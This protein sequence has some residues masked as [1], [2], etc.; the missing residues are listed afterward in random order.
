MSEN[1]LVKAYS[2]QHNLDVNEFI[3][4]YMTFLNNILNDLWQTIEWKKKGKRLIPLIRKDKFF[5]KEIRDKYI[6]KWI[7]SKHYID[8]AIKQAYSIINSWRKRYLKGKARRDKPTLKRKFVRIKETL[9]NYRNGIIKIS[10][11][12]FQENISIDLKNAWFW[13]RIKGLDLGELILKEDKIIITVRKKVKLK[14]ENPV[15]WDIN[16]LTIDGYDEEKDY[17][18][19]LK[20]IY[21]IHRIYELKRKKI[22]KLPEKT[23]KGLL[24]KYSSRE[25]NRINDILHK[26]SKQLSNRTNIFEDLKSFKE[27]VARTKSR[28]MNRQNAKHDYI[29]LQK[30]I[31]YKSE[32]NGYL[33][34]YVKSKL[35]SKTCSK[36]GYINKD[37]KGA[38][39]FICPA[40]GLRMDRQKN[41]SRN[42]WNRFLNMW[43]QGFAP[44][45]AKLYEMLPMNPEG[46]ESNETQGL[47]VYSIRIHT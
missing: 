47:S 8:S 17:K 23:K 43:G 26:I 27:R 11:K 6:I 7:Y 12:P 10:I 36:C 22:Q 31:E 19:D 39:I 46:D 29:K 2:I 3:D 24:K 41:A 16:L 35:T 34:I 18:I 1:L 33:T 13:N 30:Y 20:N 38:R 4:G 15:A 21:T 5:R 14:I 45:G 40:C 44:K 9:Y 37:L 32:W 42:I 25:K 28:S